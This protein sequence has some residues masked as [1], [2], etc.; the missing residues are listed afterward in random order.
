MQAF[1]LAAVLAIVACGSGRAADLVQVAPAVEMAGPT[2][3]NVIDPYELLSF[4][5][6]QLAQL[7]LSAADLECGAI[8]LCLQQSLTSWSS[9]SPTSTPCVA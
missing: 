9:K 6:D 1:V 7:G 5:R 3:A 8:P 2:Q 4:N